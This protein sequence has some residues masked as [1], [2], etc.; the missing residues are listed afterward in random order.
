MLQ[1][2]IAQNSVASKNTF[3]RSLQI[4]NVLSNNT[5][6][7]QYMDGVIILHTIIDNDINI[8]KLIASS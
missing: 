4:S 8:E 3:V 1:K 5:D 7:N 2:C 6:S